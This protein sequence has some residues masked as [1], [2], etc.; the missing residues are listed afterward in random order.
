MLASVPRA[1]RGDKRELTCGVNLPVGVQGASDRAYHLRL[2]TGEDRDEFVS[3]LL[4]H[5]ARRERRQSV[6][7]VDE[8]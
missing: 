4:E 1:R 7:S 8:M 2:D 6:G 5:G 3:A